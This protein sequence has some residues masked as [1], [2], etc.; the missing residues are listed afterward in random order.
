MLRKMRKGIE[1]N[2]GVLK[3]CLVREELWKLKGGRC[4]VR[5]LSTNNTSAS[6]MG[7]RNN[8]S[9]LVRPLPSS[10]SRTDSAV[11]HSHF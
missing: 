5:M 3:S 10:V 1:R 4:V 2:A 8:Q 9:V 6:T 11:P 7:A